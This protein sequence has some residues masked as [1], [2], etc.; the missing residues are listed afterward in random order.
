MRLARY[1]GLVALLGPALT[2]CE[3]GDIVAPAGEAGMGGD[4]GSGGSSGNGGGEAGAPPVLSCGAVLGTSTCDPITGL[5]CDLAAGETCD[6]LDA[7]GG[8][9]CFLGSN[10]AGFC[11]ACD[12]EA[13][14]CAAG[15]TCNP[16]LGACERFC[17]ADSDCGIGTCLLNPFLDDAVGVVGVCTE[18][19]TATCGGGGGEAGGGGGGAGGGPP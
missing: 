10:D 8:Y 1:L 9:T 14:F 13:T 19:A 16:D 11:E 18:Q 15:M 6:Y 7:D 4:D 12:F 5:P 3:E 2:N 17:C